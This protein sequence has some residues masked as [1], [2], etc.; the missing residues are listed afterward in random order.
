MRGAIEFAKQE[1]IKIIIGE[2]V[3]TQEGEVIGLF[4]EKEIQP[5]LTLEETVEKI[6]EQQGVVYLP[7]PFDEFRDSAVKIDDAEKIKNKIDLIEVFNSRTFNPKY[8]QLAQEFAKNNRII[9]VVGS[10]AHHIHELG[11]CFMELNEFNGPE[12][13]LNNI[14][15]AKYKTKKCPFLLRI[16]LKV[17]RILMGKK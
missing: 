2:E 9:Q 1:D 13:F 6:K 17:L 10:D 12:A 3:R 5:G 16:Y 4:L 8:N 14:R 15:T 11:H 7:H